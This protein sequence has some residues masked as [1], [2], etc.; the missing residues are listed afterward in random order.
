MVLWAHLYTILPPPCGLGALSLARRREASS[1]LPPCLDSSSLASAS[2]LCAAA[3]ARLTQE[4]CSA[5]PTP[6]R[7]EQCSC[8]P[9][10]RR[11]GGQG[12]SA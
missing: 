1:A 7:V 3:P 5:H 4:A 12:K 9:S 6:Q 10:V 8:R 11:E 2:R